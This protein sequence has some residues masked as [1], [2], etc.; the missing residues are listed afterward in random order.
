MKAGTIPGRVFIQGLLKPIMINTMVVT[1]HA[2][3]AMNSTFTGLDI[4][5]KRFTVTAPSR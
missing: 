4:G 2:M 3:E 1:P 5:V